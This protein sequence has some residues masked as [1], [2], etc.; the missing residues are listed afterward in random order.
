MVARWPD[1]TSGST[2]RVQSTVKSTYVTFFFVLSLTYVAETAN[3]ERST[4]Y[5]PITPITHTQSAL[6][7]QGIET[8][9]LL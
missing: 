1:Q 3:L 9:D 7:P 2:Y 6:V 8:I 4:T 5:L